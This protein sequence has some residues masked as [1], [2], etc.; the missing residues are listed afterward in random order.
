M[1]TQDPHRTIIPGIFRNLF[2]L[3][4][5]IKIFGIGVLVAVVFGTIM[6]FHTRS[7]MSISLY[8]NLEDLAVSEA[9]SLGAN[10]DLAMATGDLVSI[11]KVLT[12]A[13]Q[14]IPDLRYIL[15]RDTDGRIIAHTFARAVPYDLIPLHPSADRFI[16]SVRLLESNEGKIIEVTHP[17]IEGHGGLLQVGM[18]D[19]MVVAEVAAVTRSVLYGLGISLIICFALA[20]ILTHLLTYPIQHLKKASQQI[21]EGDFTARSEV[22]SSDEIGQLAES[23]NQ[24]AESLQQYRQE[25][26]DKENARLT[27]LKKIVHVQ[28]EVRKVLSQELHDEVGQSLLAILLTIQSQCKYRGLNGTVCNELEAKL[29]DLV[30]KIH[31]LAW[32][33]RPSI[34]DDSGLE[35]ALARF[36]EEAEKH[37]GINIDYQYTCLPDR[38][39]IPDTIE[40]TL[41]RIAQEAMANIVR[42]A[43]AGQVSVVVLQRKNEVT[44]IIEDNGCGF[45]I[46]RVRG[47]T[48]MGLTGMRERATLQDGTW[49]IE[50]TPGHG[51]TV[52]VRIPLDG[53]TVC[54]SES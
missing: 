24:M 29:R 54:Q 18:L 1:K 2:S 52:R 30:G 6:L 41:Y 28:E 8:R 48:C 17:I 22:F 3:P 11:Q 15:V 32:G 5:F 33:M 35:I 25:V 19:H 36:L 34:L 50:S 23:F 14:R 31:R 9:R 12:Q 38:K 37:S 44:L 46:Q 42:H 7:S 45:D 26:E 47:D 16:S 53:A 27:L 51:T 20:H 43:N 49:D 39:R 13:L 4:I 10:L 40:V 21:K